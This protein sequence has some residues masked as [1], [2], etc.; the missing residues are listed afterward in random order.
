MTIIRYNDI[1]EIGVYDT[2]TPDVYYSMN[3]YKVW[4]AVT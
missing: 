1:V 3:E 4:I 2:L